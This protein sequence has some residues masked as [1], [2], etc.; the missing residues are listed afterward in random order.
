MVASLVLQVVCKV[1]EIEETL[2]HM[3]QADLIARYNLL[4]LQLDLSI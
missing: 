3:Q 4:V 1:G 2:A